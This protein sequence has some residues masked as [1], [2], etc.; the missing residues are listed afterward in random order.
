MKTMTIREVP[1][2][3][4]AA[5]CAQAETSHRSIQEQ[6]RYVLEKEAR[7]RGGGFRQSAARW[8]AKFDG[9]KLGGTVEDIRAGRAR[10]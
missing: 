5:I 9:R 4:Y 8:R 10:K 2:Q 7:I 6:V 3:V 1:D